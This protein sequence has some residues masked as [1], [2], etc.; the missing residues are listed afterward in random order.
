VL[1]AIG[2]SALT[3]RVS[4][5][6]A[7]TIAFVIGAASVVSASAQA[8]YPNR[9]SGTDFVNPDFAALGT[10]YRALGIRVTRDNEFLPALQEALKAN[11]PA[12]IE[13]MTELEYIS[14]SATL[15]PVASDLP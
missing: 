14:P 10:A 6:V 9:P 15:F 3:R 1:A 2:F 4:P 8:Q 5:R 12:L 7:G 11:K 13:V